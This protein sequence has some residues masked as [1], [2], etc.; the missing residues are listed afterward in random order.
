MINADRQLPEPRFDEIIHAPIR[1]RICGLLDAYPSL[2]FDALRD[3]LEISD[4]TC[5][6]HLKVLSEHGYVRL[7]KKIGEDKGY[8]VTWVKL[9]ETGRKA[10]KAHAAALRQIVAGS[11]LRGAQ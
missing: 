3:S 5:S 1:L 4:A 11:G 6:K 8:K 10:F 2:R 7:S 9:T